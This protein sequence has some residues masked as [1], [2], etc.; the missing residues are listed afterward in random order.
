MIG[1]IEFT[2]FLFCVLFDLSPFKR[3]VGI[4]V[5]FIYMKFQLHPEYLFDAKLYKVAT[6]KKMF[7]IHP[8]KFKTKFLPQHQ[9]RTVG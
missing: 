2:V 3:I 6:P 9:Y 7:E 1:R 4:H 5:S 8:F